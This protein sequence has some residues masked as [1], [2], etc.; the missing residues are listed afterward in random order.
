V[1]EPSGGL[2]TLIVFLPALGA[3]GIALF[4]ANDRAIRW[5]ATV[6]TGAD[7]GLALFAWSVMS[8]GDAGVIG[9]QIGGYDGDAWI[10]GL[11]AVYKLSLDGLSLPMVVLTGLLGLVAV[12][13]S[14]RVTSRVREYHAWLL[15]LLTGV[16]GVFAA[17][18]LLLFFLFWEVE[19][20]PMFFLISVWGTGNKEHSAMKFVLYTLFG[21]AF[22]LVGILVLRASAG[23][24][25]MEA[26]ALLGQAG[27]IVPKFLTLNSV[28]FLFLL[29]FAIKLPV[30]PLHTWLPDTHT[31]A[32]TAV[33]VLL[34]GVL[35]KMGGYGLIRINLGFFP[36]AAETWGPILAVLAVVNILYGAAVVFRQNDLK[37]L[38]AYSSVSH[39]G[40]VLLGIASV[41]IVG[42][43]G[44]ALQMF[45]HG[46][47]TGLL[48]LVVGLM[49]DKAHTRWI[50]DLGGFA[51]HMPIVAA[52]TVVGGLASL[53]LPLLSG[54]AA[55]LVIFLGVYGA[56][57]VATIFAVFGVVLT[58]GYILWTIE[59]V[60]FGPQKPRFAGIRD[61]S[62]VD[63]VAMGLLVLPI[64]VV[65]VYP[66]L[67]MDIFQPAVRLIIGG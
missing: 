10:P 22:M 56:Q 52:V 42:V 57:P 21:S 33:S 39:M 64:V 40:L 4:G 17:Q 32:P 13:S 63:G 25:D 51:A 15:I 24:F 12:L 26:L 16:L 60:L 9:E 11:N 3:A 47:I 62:V 49:Y 58:A 45:A 31:D 37:R 55:E 36:G 29:A 28:F 59:R 30:W 41:G 8:G 65:G 53:G 66:A 67:L 19:L 27:D 5:V 23:T 43:T 38:I 35:L 50:P 48:F 18:D 7:L 34:A 1:I 44:A 20:V 46:T 54:F 14:W 2:I 61:A 6:I